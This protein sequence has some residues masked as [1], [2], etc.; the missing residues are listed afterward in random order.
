MPDPIALMAESLRRR[1]V[2]IE[3]I[4]AAAAE[5][6]A[7]CPPPD[8]PA[9]IQRRQSSWVS[10]AERQRMEDEAARSRQGRGSVAVNIR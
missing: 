8:P 10:S 1:G 7:L 4:R 2:S 6:R 3:T 9:R 5:A